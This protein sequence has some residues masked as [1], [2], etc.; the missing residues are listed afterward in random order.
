MV[1]KF[2][3]SVGFEIK[4]CGFSFLDKHIRSVMAHRPLMRSEMDHTVLTANYTM[5]AFTRQLQSI[6]ALWLVLIL[7][8]RVG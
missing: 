1:P 7:L 4:N 3:L 8:S 2:L 6:T 5:P